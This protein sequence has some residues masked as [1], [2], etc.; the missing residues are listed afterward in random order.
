MQLPNLLR[1]CLMKSEQ[2]QKYPKMK[3]DRNLNSLLNRKDLKK[4]WNLV[5]EG[6][7]ETCKNARK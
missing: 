4:L 3:E 7:V 1:L 2:L 6:T 5:H